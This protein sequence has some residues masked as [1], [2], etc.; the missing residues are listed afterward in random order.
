M[1][2]S[3]S[4]TNV[5]TSNNYAMSLIKFATTNGITMVDFFAPSNAVGP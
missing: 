4:I 2:P 1:A 5:T 3:I